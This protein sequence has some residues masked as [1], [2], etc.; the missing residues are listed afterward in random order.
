MKAQRKHN[1]HNTITQSTIAAWFALACGTGMASPAL[2]V[3]CR[4]VEPARSDR[5]ELVCSARNASS[6]S[7]TCAGSIVARTKGGGRS[8]KAMQWV[9]RPG[10][11][12]VFTLVRHA[13]NPGMRIDRFK[14]GDMDSVCRPVVGA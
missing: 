3:E 4:V 6:L 7:Q 12:R 2:D 5:T 11:V 14:S 10:D 9:M 8:V 13:D 1:M